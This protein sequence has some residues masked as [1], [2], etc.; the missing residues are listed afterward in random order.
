[1]AV[2]DTG[3]FTLPDKLIGPW[4]E[5]IQGGSVI[6]TLSDS[7]PMTYG[8]ETAMTFDWGE[9]EYV[10]EGANKSASDFTA[11]TMTTKPYKFQKTIRWTEEVQ[12]ADE[13]SQIDVV[14][15]SLN[16]L[17]PALS[18]AL[19]FGVIHGIDPLSGAPVAAMSTSLSDTTNS[20]EVAAQANYALIDA[21]DL[22]VL[23][24]NYVPTSIALDPSFAAAFATDRV[25]DTGVKRYPEFN[26]TTA[27][28]T[29]EGHT[30]STSRTVGAVG[31]AASATNVKAIVGD[32]NTVRWG[33]QR[34]IG[35][36]VIRYG[37]PDGQGDLKRNNQIAFRLEVLYGWGIADTDAVAKIIDAV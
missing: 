3:D 27:P 17:T 23:A 24:D 11:T 9:A 30:A 14:Q 2:L 29:L 4:L 25:G 34:R 31:V 7:T 33:V 35:I 19:D 12:W 36:E 32:F 37:D 22:L 20:V 10:G 16:Q 21:A 8:T 6:A 13:D 15:Q 5:K 26:L 18:R 1:M 28:S